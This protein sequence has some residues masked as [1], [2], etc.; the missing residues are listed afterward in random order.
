MPLGRATKLSQWQAKRCAAA[1]GFAAMD[2][3]LSRAAEL[4]DRALAALQTA[5]ARD[6]SL[7]ESFTCRC[8][9]LRDL[10]KEVEAAI[11]R[12]SRDRASS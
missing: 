12:T 4:I 9:H 11:E 10:R 6:P 8:A 5:A 2:D 3:E 7:C 1:V